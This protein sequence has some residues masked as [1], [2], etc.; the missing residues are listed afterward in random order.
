MLPASDDLTAALTRAT[1]LELPGHGEATRIQVGRA[2]LVLENRRGSYSMLW[3][4][5][6]EAR[7]FILGITGA[8]KL[9][10]EL[11]APRLPLTCVPRDVLTMVPGARIRGYLTIPLVPTIV[12]RAQ[13]EQPQSLVELIPSELEGTW[14]PESGHAFRVGVDWLSRFPFRSGAVQC[15]VPIRLC[16]AGDLVA[17]PS[18]LE[19]KIADDDLFEL[20]GALIVRPRRLRWSSDQRFVE[21]V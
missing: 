18:S 14:D 5:G 20:R 15:V 21:A 4:D 19:L 9:S 13:L 12:W 16:N 10:V 7:R 1:E 2:E 17:C 6:R 8:G 11:R 3:S